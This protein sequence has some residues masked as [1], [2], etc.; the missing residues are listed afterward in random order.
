MPVSMR[1]IENKNKAKTTVF[2]FLA[3]KEKQKGC[4]A[5]K[6]DPHP[7]GICYFLLQDLRLKSV[8][9]QSGSRAS[10][11]TGTIRN[12]RSSVKNHFCIHRVNE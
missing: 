11:E 4:T 8:F 1:L 12:A 6:T 3:R 9:S 10:F 7:H 2:L 5:E